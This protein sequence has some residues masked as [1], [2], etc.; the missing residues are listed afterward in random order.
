MKVYSEELVN[1]HTT[2]YQY[3]P[4]VTKL[5]GGGYVVVWTSREQDGANDGIYAQRFTAS[6]VPTGP[7]IRVNS[8]TSNYQ[9]EPGVTAL[10]DGSFAVVWTDR[11]GTDGSSYG[12]FMQRVSAAGQPLGGEQKVNTYTNADQAQPSIAAYT[13]GYI[14]TWYSNG[15]DGGGYGV[16]G[17]RYDNAGNAVLT[18]GVNEFRINTNTSSNQYE[19]AVD[20]FSAGSF[21]VVWRSEGQDGSGA[22]VYGQRYN[23][24]GSTAGSEFRVNTTTVGAQYEPKVATLSDAGVVVGGRGDDFGLGGLRPYLGPPPRPPL[25]Q[26]VR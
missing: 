18:N 7:E 4:A 9:L 15:Q 26:W 5:A 16:Y 14:V 13:G 11:S 22:G 2:D 21:V 6:G 10:S 1:T 19:P 23:A 3:E 25:P 24:D 8:T 20:A 12:V 17:Q